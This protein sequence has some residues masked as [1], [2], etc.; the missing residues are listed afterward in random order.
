MTLSNERDQN[1]MNLTPQITTIK[2]FQRQH[3]HMT[4]FVQTTDELILRM[5]L[6]FSFKTLLFFCIGTFVVLL[7]HS[8]F[9][10]YLVLLT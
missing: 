9:Y 7:L 2:L 6:L 8:C 10:F 3:R 5:A 4:I 1:T